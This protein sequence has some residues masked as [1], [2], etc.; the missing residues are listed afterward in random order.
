LR[1][2]KNLV[3]IEGRSMQRGSGQ[4]SRPAVR[5]ALLQTGV[6]AL[7]FLAVFAGPAAAADPPAANKPAVLS[8]AQRTKLLTERNRLWQEANRLRGKGK[9]NEA[10]PAARQAL[11]IERQLFG[12]ANADI[13]Q[14]LEWL[15]QS[16]LKRD[17]FDAARTAR[18]E[19]SAIRTK[20][21]GEKDWRAADARQAL[22]DVDI[23][24]RLTVEQRRELLTAEQANSQVVALYRKGDFRQA[25]QFA[26][27]V[28]NIRRLA[29]FGM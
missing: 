20:L 7:C 13:A 8:K 12:K 1:H 26:E 22:R 2:P 18:Q 29:C 6:V 27:Q 17:E 15:A 28:A 5:A 24:S 23:R 4:R 16:H 3:L 14:S 10:I 21:Y 19:A 25:I 9:L 11:A